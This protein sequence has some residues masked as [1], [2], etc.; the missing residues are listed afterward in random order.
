ME[1]NI[2]PILRRLPRSMEKGNFDP[3]AP[4]KSKIRIVII[5]EADLELGRIGMWLHFKL[6][7]R[8]TEWVDGIQ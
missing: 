2:G 8:W 1:F 5:P 3:L 4:P 6:K 7:G